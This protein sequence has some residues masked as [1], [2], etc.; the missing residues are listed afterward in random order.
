MFY[1][2][3]RETIKYYIF[4]LDVSRETKKPFRRRV[5]RETFKVVR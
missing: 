4:S 2:V 1:I 5:S 3:S